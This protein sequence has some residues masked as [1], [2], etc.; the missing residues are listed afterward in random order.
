MCVLDRRKVSDMLPRGRKEE[1][2]GGD[3]TEWTDNVTYLTHYT[4]LDHSVLSPFLPGFPR[5]STIPSLLL[6]FPLDTYHHHMY[7]YD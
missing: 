1:R 4:S 7:H 2:R 6:L 5:L 3:V